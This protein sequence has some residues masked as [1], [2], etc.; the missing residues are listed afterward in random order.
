MKEVSSDHVA[1][2]GVWWRGLVT[3]GVALLRNRRDDTPA[4]VGQVQIC[5][6]ITSLFCLFLEKHLS[7]FFDSL[8]CIKK[9]I[10]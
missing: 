5:F 10:I 4:L 2:H 7:F 1:D 6:C 3:G 8:H 9:T